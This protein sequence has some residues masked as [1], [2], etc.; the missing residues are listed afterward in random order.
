[1]IK[2]PI[3]GDKTIINIHVPNSKTPKYTKQK[4]NSREKYSTVL[5]LNSTEMAFKFIPLPVMDK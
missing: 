3:Q 2:R 1:M 4:Q 5:V